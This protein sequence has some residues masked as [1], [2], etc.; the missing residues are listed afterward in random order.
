[1]TH[2]DIL[3]VKEDAT[4]EEIKQAYRQKALQY[5]P[6]RN[7]SNEKSTAEFKKIVAAFETLMDPHKKFVYNQ[8]LP[9]KAERDAREEARNFFKDAKVEKVEKEV[10][11]PTLH[12]QPPTHDLWGNRLTPEERQQWSNDL[13]TDPRR[14]R[15]QRPVKKKDG[16]YDVF[17]NT[18]EPDDGTYLR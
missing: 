15:P 18:Y 11:A 6:D 4:N 17:S 12:A 2:Y 9:K 3:G 1:M 14:L 5:H 7:P 13:R 16:F 10:V 8:R